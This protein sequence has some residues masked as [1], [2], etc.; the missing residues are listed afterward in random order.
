MHSIITI[1]NA[2]VTFTNTKIFFFI[3]HQVFLFCLENA[4]RCLKNNFKNQS[5]KL[6]L[7]NTRAFHLL[8]AEALCKSRE[9]FN[10][11]EKC[12]NF[13]VVLFAKI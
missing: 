10:C 4:M 11:K 12:N 2:C 5:F 1:G 6:K 3:F 13:S 8:I 9:N 7:Q